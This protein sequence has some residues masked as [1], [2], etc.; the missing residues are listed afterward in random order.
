M[1][2]AVPLKKIT[3]AKEEI[4][5]DCDHSLTHAELTI[6]T[7]NQTG[8][9]AYVMHKFEELEIN[10]IT[11]KIHSSKYKV[12]DSFLMEKQ[13]KICNNIESIYEAL[14]NDKK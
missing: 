1:N 13:N 5:I 14:S 2:R 12:R 4:A 7:S 3:I 8:L 9:L 10:V 6:R 11:A